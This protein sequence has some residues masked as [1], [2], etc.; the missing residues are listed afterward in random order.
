MVHAYPPMIWLNYRHHPC[1][2]INH[3]HFLEPGQQYRNSGSECTTDIDADVGG[4][5]VRGAVYVQVGMLLLVSISRLFHY[6]ATGVKALGPGL[7][8]T[9]FS[10]NI[11]LLMR[12][13]HSD[14][15]VADAAIAAMILDAQNAAL[16]IPLAAKETLA[17]RWQISVTAIVQIMGLVT[18]LILITKIDGVALAKDNCRHMVFF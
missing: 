8:L 5:G 18:L 3:H 13:G 11:A 7:L 4:D 15:N 1:D 17:S 6:R 16:S 12:V 10:F 2:H 14:F 9:E